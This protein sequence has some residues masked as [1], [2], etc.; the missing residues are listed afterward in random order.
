M[1]IA[2]VSK[3]YEITAD[4]LRYYERI[5]LIPTVHRNVSGIRDY[6]EEDCNWVQFIKCMRGAGLSIESLV[7]YVTLFQ[8]GDSTLEARKLLLIEERKEVL[9]RIREMNEVLERLNYK[10]KNYETN[11]AKLNK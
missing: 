8:Q 7:E 11:A 10:I 2:E 6:S 3:K 9:K 1:L 4:T 5:G